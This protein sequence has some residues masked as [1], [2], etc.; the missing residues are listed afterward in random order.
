MSDACAWLDGE[1]RLADVGPAFATLLGAPRSLL[2]GRPLDRAVRLGSPLDLGQAEWSA[3]GRPRGR[4]HA[5]VRLE[6]RREADG[7]TRLCG[8]DVTTAR[9]EA[10]FREAVARLGAVL[11]GEVTSELELELSKALS[12]VL[13]FD[14]LRLLRRERRGRSDSV[15]TAQ[16]AGFGSA[17]HPFPAPPPPAEDAW[18]HCRALGL[19]DD[20]EG[21]RFDDLRATTPALA[22]RQR[23]RD[24]GHLGTILLPL[25]VSER[26][27]AVLCLDR[28]F[29]GAPHPDE[30]DALASLAPLVAAAV[31]RK[32]LQRAVVDSASVYA[33]VFE[34]AG[35]AIV[36]ADVETAAITDVNTRFVE[37]AGR[38]RTALQSG[39]SLGAVVQD[40][41]EDPAER[42]ARASRRGVSSLEWIR[43]PSGRLVP[44]DVTRR[45]FTWRGRPTELAVMRD[46]RP[47]LRA[48][49][50]VRRLARAID[51]IGLGVFLTR[52]NG[53]I[54]FV[55]PAGAR[56]VGASPR[57]LVGQPVRALRSLPTDEDFEGEASVR[58]FR[59]TSLTVLVS[60]A[61]FKDRDGAPD[62]AVEIWTDLT[63]QKQ[64]EQRLIEADKL[65][66]LGQAAA[67]VAHEINNPL[68]FLFANLEAVSE[69][70]VGLRRAVDA[71]RAGLPEP[72]DE[73]RRALED[74]E[75]DQAL[76]DLPTLVEESLTGLRRVRR[77]VEDLRAFARQRDLM[78]SCDLAEVVAGTLALARPL[79][80]D[81]VT[82]QLESEPELPPIIGVPE[83]LEQVTLNLIV[84][85]AQAMPRPR[86]DGQS[87]RIDVRLKA[88]GRHVVCEV[89]DNGTGIA[90]HVQPHVF[91]RFFTTKD[92]S[93]GTG[94]GLYV[95][96]KVLTQH[97]GELSVEST[98]GV[99][100][101]FRMSLPV[102]P[103]PPED[104][105]LRRRRRV[106]LVDRDALVLAWLGRALAIHHDVSTADRAAHART[107]LERQRFD[108]I[109]CERGLDDE[110]GERLFAELQARDPHH[111]ARFVLMAGGATSP[112]AEGSGPLPAHRVLK[113]VRPE[114]L[115]ALI[116]SL[117]GPAEPT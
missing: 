57:Q 92:R 94:L 23:S 3:E 64:T 55:N 96:R 25:R 84:N 56:L 41:P 20:A 106:L 74:P 52:P 66:S 37:L 70:G 68:A 77:I 9:R 47:R 88:D 29:A 59:G 44:V 73:A 69:Y 6:A 24:D 72:A 12:G 30:A 39:L 61:R 54:R 104:A 26:L 81:G 93:Q 65:A 80:R 101:T 49:R 53:T 40:T 102:A 107:L 76:E 91:E 19:D 63:E 34:T 86:T 27:S 97:G 45:L 90:P 35:E 36:L 51:A 48:E 16:S 67:G 89:S 58:P 18:A 5:W 108:A 112:E 1:G 21:P 7:R 82:I 100:T 60:R 15:V 113:P 10:T 109:L 28:S 75:V 115:L 17:E 13:P 99:G 117:A 31:D 71:A 116:E 111:A 33:S 98:E 50:Q 46:A 22:Q 32:R 2:Q 8:T 79:T 95:C 4:P 38:P 43:R 110:P 103:R 85:A 114:T 42:L 11:S 62:G 78:Q 14:R 87:S 105:A 83:R